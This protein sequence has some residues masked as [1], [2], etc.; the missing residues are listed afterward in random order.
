MTST[1]EELVREYAA[2]QANVEPDLARMDDIKKVLRDLEYGTHD[3]AGLQVQISRNGRLD[4]KRFAEQYP[5]TQRPEFYKTAP[6]TKEIRR[7]LS[8]KEVEALST[9]GDKKVSIK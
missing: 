9:E 5:V 1:H 6:D 4:S 3:L 2:L 7:H 8:P